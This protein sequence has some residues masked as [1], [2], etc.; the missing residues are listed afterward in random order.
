[1]TGNEGKHFS[2]LTE[3]Q[4]NAINS[5]HYPEWMPYYEGIT[6]IKEYTIGQ[7]C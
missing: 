6:V 3:I 4:I 7:K 5:Q 1:M 2:Y